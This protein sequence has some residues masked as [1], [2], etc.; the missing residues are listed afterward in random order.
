[1][2]GKLSQTNKQH[3][4]IAK[5]AAADKRTRDYACLKIGITG[6]SIQHW[7]LLLVIPIFQHA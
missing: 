6:D 1:M 5:F 4:T 7:V 2:R 3:M